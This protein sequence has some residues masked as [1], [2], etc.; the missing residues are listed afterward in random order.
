M[1]P[2]AW[3]WFN[4]PRAIAIDGTVYAGAISASGDVQVGASSRAVALHA[5]LETDDHD[6]PA[7]LSA[8]LGWPDSGLLQPARG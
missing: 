6:N 7:L 1:I 2:G 4:D 3:T 5:A 8:S